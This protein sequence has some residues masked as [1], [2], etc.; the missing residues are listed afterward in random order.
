MAGNTHS[1][2]HLTSKING[3]HIQNIKVP[4]TFSPSMTNKVLMYYFVAIDKPLM[5]GSSK[6]PILT[7][8]GVFRKVASLAPAF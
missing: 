8:R 1:L 5:S 7:Q 6:P 4:L 3:N 2:F